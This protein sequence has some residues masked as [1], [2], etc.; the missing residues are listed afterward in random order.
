M[1]TVA[2]VTVAMVTWCLVGMGVGGVLVT[3]GVRLSVSLAVAMRTVGVAM[4]V[5]MGTVCVVGVA[6]SVSLTTIAVLLVMVNSAVTGVTSRVTLIYQVNT[7]ERVS[8]V[9]KQINKPISKQNNIQTGTKLVY[10]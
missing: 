7:T 5:A 1:V 4:A 6:V 8:T 9:N 2:M 3:A 10:H